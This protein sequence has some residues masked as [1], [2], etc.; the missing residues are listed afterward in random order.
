[1]CIRDRAEGVEVNNMFDN[2][3]FQWMFLPE[4][5]R[6]IGSKFTYKIKTGPKGEV[7]KYKARLVAKGYQQIPGV[8]YGD[9][10]A[11]VAGATAFRM[12]VCIALLKDWKTYSWDVDAAFLH[13]ELDRK[14]YMRPPSGY[15]P[16]SYTHLTLPTN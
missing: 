9:T 4:G 2:K 12:L 7:I 11:P 10:S 1:M 5:E 14:I 6:T 8:D 13:G 16:V 15:V 3:V